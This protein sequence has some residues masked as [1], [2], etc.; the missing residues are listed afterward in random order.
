MI[1]K[2]APTVRA[3]VIPKPKTTAKSKNTKG[4]VGNPSLDLLH[5]Q[6]TVHSFSPQTG[7]MLLKIG[8]VRNA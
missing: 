3:A 4:F 8:S 7:E 6:G 2:I 5:I 1:K